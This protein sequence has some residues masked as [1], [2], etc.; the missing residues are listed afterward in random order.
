MSNKRLCVACLQ[1]SNLYKAREEKYQSKIRVL[2][3]IA[4]GTTEEMEVLLVSGVCLLF[5][6]PQL[7]LTVLVSYRLL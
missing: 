2:E 1:Q 4:T 7:I 3:T 5:L 6:F